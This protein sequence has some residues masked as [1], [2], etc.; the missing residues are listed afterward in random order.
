VQPIQAFIQSA[1]SN[2]RVS[3]ESAG[4]ATGELLW[5]I[6]NEMPADAFSELT[7]ELPGAAALLPAEAN[8]ADIGLG[9]AIPAFDSSSRGPGVLGA[10]GAL[11]SNAI[12][13]D[14]VAPFCALFMSFVKSAAGEGLYYRT[15]LEVADLRRLLR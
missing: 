6:R 11:S 8:A 10:L 4:A 5:L 15:L 12:S 1:A 2:L 9:D 13:I 3:E 7:G 14:Q